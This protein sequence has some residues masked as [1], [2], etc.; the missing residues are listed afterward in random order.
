MTK[1][2]IRE[3]LAKNFF[4]NH[5]ILFNPKALKYDIENGLVSLML[6]YDS[7]LIREEIK[8]IEKKY[9]KK[10]EGLL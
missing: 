8:I 9:K 2:K 1:Q 10:E 6:D 3:I 7:E 5:K 4:L